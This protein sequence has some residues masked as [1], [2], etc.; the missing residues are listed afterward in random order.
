MEVFALS[1][2][3]R[4]A[5]RPVLCAGTELSPLTQSG[6]RVVLDRDQDGW[7]NRLDN[8]PAFLNPSQQDIDGDGE[9]KCIF[10]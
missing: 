1:K 2:S 4:C 10:Q 6:Q 8:C 5:L 3:S 7:F 9:A